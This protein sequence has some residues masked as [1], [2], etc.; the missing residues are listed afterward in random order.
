MS[1]HLESP[2][3]STADTLRTIERSR[4]RALVQRNVDLA[5]PLHA[6]DFQLV[7]PVGMTLTRAQYLGA[8]Q[9]GQLV[10]T[11]WDPHD[12]DVRLHDHIAALRYR[13]SMQ[14]SFGTHQVPQADYWHTD[15]Y[16]QRDGTWQ[17]V[18]SQAT[19]IQPMR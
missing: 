5:A 17:V 7:T 14:V 9:S 11:S 12:I 15:L 8:I 1:N 13:S 18:W 4:V 2:A 16:E 10:Y 19:T 3:H 6:A